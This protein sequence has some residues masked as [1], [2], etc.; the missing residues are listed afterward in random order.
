VDVYLETR[1]SARSTGY[2]FLGKGPGEPWWRRRYG[3]RTAFEYPTILVERDAAGWRAYLGGIPSSRCEPGGSTNRVAIVLDAPA[4]AGDDDRGL[5][6]RLIAAWLHDSAEGREPGDIQRVLDA[7]FS[8]E[9][10]ARLYTEAI[11]GEIYAL[12]REAAL[13]LPS[14]TSVDAL[15]PDPGPSWIAPIR[16]AAA[17][18]AFLARVRALVAEADDGAAVLVNL[19]DDAESYALGEAEPP[20]AVL[21]TDPDGHM[22]ET[23]A[24]LAPKKALAPQPTPPARRLWRVPKRAAVAAIMAAVAVVLLIIWGLAT[25]GRMPGGGTAPSGTSPAPLPTP[26]DGS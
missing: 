15:G 25:A 3:E 18:A 19:V 13:L 1:G 24:P 8:E 20:T 21:T 26:A 23:P 11:P 12:V 14:V 17:R 6:L 2:K 5:A 4:E 16:G 9:T 7:V 22:D 10:V